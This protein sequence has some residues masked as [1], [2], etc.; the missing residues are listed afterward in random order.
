MISLK[1]TAL[2]GWWVIA[3]WSFHHI[4]HQC[5]VMIAMIHHIVGCVVPETW[6]NKRCADSLP[7]FT[8]SILKIFLGKTAYDQWLGSDTYSRFQKIEKTNDNY[9]I[10]ADI[11]QWLLIWTEFWLR[12]KIGWWLSFWIDSTTNV[13]DKHRH[14]NTAKVATMAKSQLNSILQSCPHEP[15]HSQ[16]HSKLNVRKADYK[17]L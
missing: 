15:L 2:N 9:W 3:P 12:W 4:Q 6:M 1:A 16:G 14:D 11:G 10:W 13:K 7:S 8:G 17:L 5:Q